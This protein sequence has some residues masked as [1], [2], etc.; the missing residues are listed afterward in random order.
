MARL[1][2][3][4]KDSPETLEALRVRHG[5]L[6][7]L[8]R[9]QRSI[10]HGAPLHEVLASIAAGA[11]ELLGDPVAGLRL[12]DEED[13]QRMTLV[14]ATGL[15]PQQVAE[16]RHGV[17]GQG[18]G[19]R[20]IVTGEVVVVEDYAEASD[21]IAQFGEYG[22]QNALAAPVRIGGEVA[23]SLTVASFE[24]GRRYDLV[25]Q[26]ILLALAE[27]AG[28]A[29]LDASLIDRRERLVARRGAARFH[30]LV[31]HSTD[32]IAI[33]DA[34]GVVSF[35]TPSL[36][37]ALGR[38]SEVL[39]GTTLLAHVHP[40]D[41][42]QAAAHLR[43][44]AAAAGTQPPVDWRLVPPGAQFLPD[45]WI[46]AEVLATNLIDDPDVGGIV[47]NGRDV[48]ERTRAE[49][50]RRE[51]DAR[52]RQIVDTTHDGV[53][54]TDR[55][56]RTIFVNRAL[57]GMLGR[58]PE[59]M[60]GR[61]P[62]DFMTPDQAAIA[63]RALARRKRGVNDRYEL[64]LVRADGS[65]LHM[66]VSGTAVFEGERFAGT[67]ALCGDITELVHAREENAQLETRLRKAQELETLGRLAGHVAHDFNQVLAVI[68]GFA[69][70]LSEQA[71]AGAPGDE[72]R[73]I[74]D[75]A[76]HG[77]ALARQL[78]LFSRHGDGDP[79]VLDL[80]EATRATVRLVEAAAPPGA[81]VESRTGQ[82]PLPVR[83]DPTKLRQIL[84]NLVDNAFDAMATGGRLVITT[85]EVRLTGAPDEPA[86]GLPPGRY[87]GL[88]VADDGAG[89]PPEVQA[90]ALEPAFTTKPSGR[91]SGLGLAIVHGAVQAA[92]GHVAIESRPGAGTTARVLLP[93]APGTPATD[94]DV[95]AGGQAS[96][97]APAV[98]PAATEILLVEDDPSVLE[99]TR[100]VLV[101]QGYRVRASSDPREAV[102]AMQRG[103]IDLLVTD[104]DMPGTSG[105]QLVERLREIAPRTPAIVMSGYVAE[106]GAGRPEDVAW[107]P[108]P[109]G[110]TALLAAVRAALGDG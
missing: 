42:P 51:Q 49:Q 43:A 76:E 48:T 56:D 50:A 57:A 72:L 62:Q 70:R 106:A 53:W 64:V 74:V 78:V 63:R 95:D 11:A 36:G 107:L 65:P 105:V 22:V 17:V 55:E 38:A 4:S 98:A 18:A 28:L 10:S 69:G 30:A 73:R 85:H 9:I 71:A 5:L 96:P 79:E 75:A 52:Y 83:I 24:A 103:P 54:M 97:G 34:E 46:H 25:E 2:E 94:A 29:L 6:E 61:S 86:L 26:E 13:P 1:F 110:A 40:S 77:A 33:V 31:N 3:R 87:A 37:R 91:G 90:R 14:A 44:A 67:L 19:G 59:E 80:G 82:E 15:T 60:L 109:F 66:V 32:L 81:T 23:G 35:A 89:M 12:V 20:A 92:G 99:L 93:L 39:A 8:S 45:R 68:L 58:S 41:R 16:V 102:A 88:I 101:E 21:S 47:L 7:R 84:M 108:K 27:H 100:R 104:H